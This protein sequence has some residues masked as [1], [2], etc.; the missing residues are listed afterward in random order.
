MSHSGQTLA[1][2]MEYILASSDR[3]NN[4]AQT[5]NKSYSEVEEDCQKILK[6]ARAYSSPEAKARN[7]KY[8]DKTRARLNE[9]KEAIK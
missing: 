8:R 4:L 7:K 6:Q 1:E 9:I 3:V 2:R 5:L